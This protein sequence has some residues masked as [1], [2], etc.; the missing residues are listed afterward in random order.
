[1]QISKTIIIVI[2]SHTADI[3]YEWKLFA[4]FPGTV[5]CTEWQKIPLKGSAEPHKESNYV[6]KSKTSMSSGTQILSV[7]LNRE[8]NPKNIAKC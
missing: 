5:V 7:A 2:M 1:M 4:S 8:K 6:T 3:N